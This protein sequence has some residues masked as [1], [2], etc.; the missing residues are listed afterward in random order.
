MKKY[1]VLLLLPLPA[2]AHPGHDP[3]G[4]LHAVWHMLSS[5]NHW[6]LPLGLVVVAAVAL[7]SQRDR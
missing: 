5:F 2:W 1:F 6:L 3:V 4:W 7:A